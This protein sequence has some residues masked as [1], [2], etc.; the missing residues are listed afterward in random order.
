VPLA[1]GITQFAALVSAAVVVPKNGA[2]YGA[3]IVTAN[4]AIA[5][6]GLSRA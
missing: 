4:V 2:A 1:R 3:A 6:I 5:S